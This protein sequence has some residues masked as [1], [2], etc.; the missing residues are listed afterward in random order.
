MCQRKEEKEIRGV[1]KRSRMKRE[2]EKG[3]EIG[4]EIRGGETKRRKQEVEKK[5]I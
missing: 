4:M 1:E 5:K 2:V 3:R